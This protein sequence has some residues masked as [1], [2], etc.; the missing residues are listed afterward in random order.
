M[1]ISPSFTG[2]ILSKSNLPVLY[3]M[4]VL[5]NHWNRKW[6][7]QNG[8]QQVKLSACNS[9]D[10]QYCRRTDNEVCC[11]TAMVEKWT[12]SRAITRLS[13]L[14][15]IHVIEHHV[16]K[17]WKAKEE[18]NPSWKR[19]MGHAKAVSDQKYKMRQKCQQ[20]ASHCNLFKTLC[21]DC[22]ANAIFGDTKFATR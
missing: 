2:F 6:D 21:L 12:Q 19:I 11:I 14:L 20:K 7:R 9:N 1:N 5:F 15:S 13:R 4:N 16:R 22:L 18:G 10:F 8:N 17:K 3:L